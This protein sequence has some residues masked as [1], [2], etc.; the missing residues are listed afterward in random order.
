M[1]HAKGGSTSRSFTGLGE[2]LLKG[3][4]NVI[5]YAH[6]TGNKLMEASQSIFKNIGIILGATYFIIHLT[7]FVYGLVTKD[8][9]AWSQVIQWNR[10]MLSNF[11]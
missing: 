9:T 6:Y 8:W 4:T 10:L 5:Q 11:N 7:A 2:E 1:L 3:I